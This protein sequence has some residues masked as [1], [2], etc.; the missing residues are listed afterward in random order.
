M[1]S[2]PAINPAALTDKTILV[3][4]ASSGIGKEIAILCA[5]LGAK[6]CAVGRNSFRLN[7]TVEA[8]DGTGHQAHICD[9]TS[10]SD[11]L[12]L[13]DNLP[14]LHGVVHCAGIGSRV[15]CK[16]I[17]QSDIDAVFTVNT[18]APMLLQSALLR[19]KKITKSASIV[20][21]ASMA[22]D[23]PTA[24]NAIYSASKAAIIAYAKVLA[25][26]L[27][28]RLIRV[29]CVSPAMI[30]TDLITADGIDEYTLKEDQNNYLLKRYGQPADVANLVAYLLSDV[31]SWM[32]GEN[33]HIT[34]GLK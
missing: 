2:S 26:E 28:Q 10:Q 3:T 15:I 18:F 30:W 34:G 7:Q 27:A 12:T 8:L 20:F 25:V 19:E 9:L 21:I 14:Q 5:S 33:I 23:K 22:P 32:T 4:G 29:N 17:E 11:L 13:V 6:V 1:T 16:N 24:G 31:S